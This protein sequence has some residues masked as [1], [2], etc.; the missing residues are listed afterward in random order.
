M[1]SSQ[2]RVR[3]ATDGL[4]TEIREEIVV[5]SGG[6]PGTGVI[7]P[8]LA[9][10]ATAVNG[11]AILSPVGLSAAFLSASTTFTQGSFGAVENPHLRKLYNLALDFKYYRV[12]RGK[13]IFTP[14]VGS[15]TTGQLVMASF[16]DPMDASTVPQVAYASGPSY[17]VFNLSNTNKEISIPMDLD[18]S[19]K[20]ITSVL[21]IPGGSAPFSSTAGA[22][23]LITVNSASDLSF[24]TFSWLLTNPVANTN[25]VTYGNFSAVYEVEFKGI[26]DSAINY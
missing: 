9:A 7:T 19:W 20:K 12:T 13:I 11:T 17:R 4:R 25:S 1:S 6:V 10:N 14:N 22:S 3:A 5:G 2:K 21:S 15:T 16:R 23:A 18:S 24:T 8:T 26:I